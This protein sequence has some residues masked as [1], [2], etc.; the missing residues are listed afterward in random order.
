MAENED[1]SSAIESDTMVHSL[2]RYKDLG[3]AYISTRTHDFRLKNILKRVLT[4]M[5]AKPSGQ[6]EDLESEANEYWLGKSSI[7]ETFNYSPLQQ[8]VRHAS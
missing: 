2:L 6:L 1:D 3:D 4:S 5:F 7:T 8:P